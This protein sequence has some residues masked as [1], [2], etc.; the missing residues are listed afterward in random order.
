GVFAPFV[1]SPGSSR[2]F[3]RVVVMNGDE[4]W[5]PVELAKALV[6]ASQHPEA[7]CSVAEVDIY[8]ASVR[9]LAVPANMHMVWLKDPH[10]CEWSMIEGHRLAQVQMNKRFVDAVAN[11]DSEAARYLSTYYTVI[12]VPKL[13]SDGYENAPTLV[14]MAD[15]FVN[16]LGYV[17]NEKAR[18]E[19]LNG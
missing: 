3:F 1:V 18:A 2:D 11:G 4:F 9:S 16:N 5:H 13:A 14:G 6:L 7:R 17:W 12:D 15:V 8:W 19:F 10:R